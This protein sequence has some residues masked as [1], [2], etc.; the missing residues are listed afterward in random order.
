MH[1]LTTK[2]TKILKGRERGFII[3]GMHLLPGRTC[4]RATTGCLRSCLNT[5][6][7]G[8]Y[9]NVQEARA[10]KTALF[11][12]DLPNFLDILHEDI[13]FAI[14]QAARKRL[15]PAFRLN[16]TSDIPWEC[17]GVPQ[18]YPDVQW[19][20]YSKYHDRHP[21][22]NYHLTFS[23]SE[24]LQNHIDAKKWLKRGG[25][26]A[27]VFK[28]ELPSEYWGHRVV[29]GDIDDLRFLDP[30]PCIV[31]LSAKGRAKSD[32]TGFV[33]NLAA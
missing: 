6:G 11:W 15:R 28:G 7:H 32:T 12:N 3:Y 31:G 23:R 25:N 13:K 18:E 9:R 5:A 2:N 27:V 26:V 33:V 4:D 19:F 17:Y 16:L 1:L 20:D 10:R 8:T 22:D 30:K 14:R 21:C 24:S 29:S